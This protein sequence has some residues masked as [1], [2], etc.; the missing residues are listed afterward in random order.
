MA[1]TIFRTLSQY[2]IWFCL[3][4]IVAML[5]AGVYN[6]LAFR[7]RGSDAQLEAPSTWHAARQVLVVAN[8]PIIFGL[9][10]H[11]N[12]FSRYPLWKVRRAYYWA[13]RGYTRPKEAG[14]GLSLGQN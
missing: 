9:V 5:G 4:G 2:P 13:K 1:L 7:S 12:E 11:R 10:T 14:W 6:D 3:L 8:A